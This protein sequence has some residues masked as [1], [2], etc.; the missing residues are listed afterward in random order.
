MSL[1]NLTH[2]KYAACH[3]DSWSSAFPQS[4]ESTF[5]CHWP[6]GHAVSSAHL[7]FKIGWKI[8][9]CTRYKYAWK[10]SRIQLSWTF[11]ID[12]SKC[13]FLEW[14]TKSRC[15]NLHQIQSYSSDVFR[16]KRSRR[17]RLEEWGG[18]IGWKSCFYLWDIKMIHWS[19]TS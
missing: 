11:F 6:R 19:V 7:S 10:K 5:I 16:L 13:S 3:G 14:V 8:V 2:S 4:F 9:V 18:C 12:F 17:M 15:F 1:N